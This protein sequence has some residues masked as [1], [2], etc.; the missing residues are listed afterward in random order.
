MA[1]IKLAKCSLA[2]VYIEFQF[3][4]SLRNTSTKVYTEGCLISILLNA[5]C[6]VP[7]KYEP[8]YG[9]IATTSFDITRSEF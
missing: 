6:Q 2:Y 3:F 9:N 8:Y 7:T 5:L 4:C 1:P